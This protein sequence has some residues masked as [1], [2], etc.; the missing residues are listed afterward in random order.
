MVG[1]PFLLF[2]EKQYILGIRYF[3]N[4]GTL[5]AFPGAAGCVPSV[6]S[7][8]IGVVCTLHPVGLMNEINLL[9]VPKLCPVNWTRWHS[10]PGDPFT[11]FSL[12]VFVQ[13]L[14]ILTDELRK[15]LFLLFGLLAI[16]GHFCIRGSC[17]MKSV[18]TSSNWWVDYLPCYDLCGTHSSVGLFVVMGDHRW[19]VSCRSQW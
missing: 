18:T 17:L 5:L 2:P 10:Y 3:Y 14:E 1:I 16:A 19:G 4:T 11:F 6:F 13:K 7:Y 12:L 15:W 9:M 8:G